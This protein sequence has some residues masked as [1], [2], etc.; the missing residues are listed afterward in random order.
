MKVAAGMDTCPGC[1]Q[2]FDSVLCPSCGF[3][4]SSMLFKEK[5][6]NCGYKGVVDTPLGKKPDQRKQFST[7][8]YRV[9]I[10]MLT[11]TLIGL[12]KIYFEL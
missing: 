5:C 4:G 7:W 2:E 6:P 10:V 1:G 11:V 9:L 12:I 8:V 3:K